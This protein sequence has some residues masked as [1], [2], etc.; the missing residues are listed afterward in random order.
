MTPKT[1]NVS[2]LPLWILI[3]VL[4][5]GSAAQM[6]WVTRGRDRLVTE[7]LYEDA[8]YYFQTARNI[9]QGEGSVSS[10]GVHHNGYHPLWMRVCVWFFMVFGD[11]LTAIRATLIFSLILSVLAT[12]VAYGILRELGCAA[13]T[14]TFAGACFFLNPWMLSLSTSGLEAPLNALL[15]GL[16]LWGGIR[17]TQRRPRW[18]QAILFGLLA[19]LTYLTRTDNAFFVA[20]T[21]LFLFAR[22]LSRQRRIAGTSL[23]PGLILAGAVAFLVILPWHLWNLHRFGDFMQ[24]SAAALPVVRRIVF[25]EQNP[26]ATAADFAL[27]RLGLFAQWF[28]AILYYSGLG[29][30]WYAIFGGSALVAFFTRGGRAE[31]WRMLLA[32]LEIAPLLIAVVCLGFAHKYMRLATREWYYVPSD[33]L[34]ALVLGIATHFLWTALSKTGSRGIASLLLA[35]FLVAPAFLFLARKTLS[36][37]PAGAGWPARLARGRAGALVIVDAF[38]NLPDKRPDEVFGATDSGTIGFFCD[39]PVINL[40]GV[41]NPSAAV[42]I[43]SG[44]L[45]NYAARRGIRYLTITPRMQNGR[46]LGKDF[47]ERL[48]PVPALTHEGF[49]LVENRADTSEGVSRP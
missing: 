16:T 29:S 7:T 28:P 45:L 10:G 36:D 32:L 43:R 11:S 40:D 37:D 19:G 5:I 2:R 21:F 33:L 4:L 20:A 44:N 14:A 26:G 46:I 18:G 1:R 48:E 3:A 25:F 22:S 24:G 13:W 12:F 9:A 31:R 38:E 6:F 30:I 35:L 34:L 17:L 47:R 42:A 23:L 39:W 15:L 8:F 27:H 41:V 49:R